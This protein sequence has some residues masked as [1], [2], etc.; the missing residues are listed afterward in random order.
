MPN[1]HTKKNTLDEVNSSVKVEK[2]LSKIEFAKIVSIRQK[3]RKS[4]K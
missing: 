1:Q 2:T 3:V 4:H